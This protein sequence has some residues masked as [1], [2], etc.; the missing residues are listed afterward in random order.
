LAVV[1]YR[2]ETW[3]LTL[4]EKHRLKVFESRVQ[5][6]I[7]G[8]KRNEVM[9]GWTKLRNEEFHELYN[10]IDQFEADKMHGACSTKGGEEKHIGYWLGKPDGKR[11]LGR[12]R[13]RWVDNN[14]MN[15]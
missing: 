15:L 2:C 11:P 12:P 7:S 3:S 5:R 8:L 9:G 1:L 10:Q 4:R 6:R 13:H 14:K